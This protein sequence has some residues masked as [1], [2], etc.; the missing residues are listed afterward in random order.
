MESTE[1]WPPEGEAWMLGVRELAGTEPCCCWGP[2]VPLHSSSGCQ[3]PRERRLHV[4]PSPQQPDAAQTPGWE[5]HGRQCH[6]AHVFPLCPWERLRMGLI[7]PA[8]A[9]PTPALTPSS[10]PGCRWHLKGDKSRARVWPQGAKT[11]RLGAARS[12]A[13]LRLPRP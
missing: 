8:A 4:Q 10:A 2:G 11:R 13:A 6:R 1:N 5:P 3:H 9:S 7:L 12:M